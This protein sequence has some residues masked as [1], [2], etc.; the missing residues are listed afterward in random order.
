MLANAGRWPANVWK[1]GSAASTAIRPQH[2]RSIRT[3]D[4]GDRV[5]EP[6]VC[7]ARL[8]Y[9]VRPRAGACSGSRPTKSF[10]DCSL[11]TASATRPFAFCSLANRTAAMPTNPK[12]GPMGTVAAAAATMQI[13]ASRSCRVKRN[14][15]SG[16]KGDR[17]HG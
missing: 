2:M 1:W 11:R 5:F 14:A 12:S 8:T 10:L 16:E 6:P 15:G 3:K 17:F 13:L 9:V 7:P 4:S